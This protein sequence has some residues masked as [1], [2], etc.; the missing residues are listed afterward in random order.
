MAVALHTEMDRE[1]CTLGRR[2]PDPLS[3]P[4][5]ESR[6]AS[7]G[8]IPIACSPLWMWMPSWI[9]SGPDGV[10]GCRRGGSIADADEVELS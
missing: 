2:S 4:V 10:Q 8:S 9:S 3:E 1:P 5:A 7:P 6:E